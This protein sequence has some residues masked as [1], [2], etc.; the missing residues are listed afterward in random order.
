MFTMAM[1]PPPLDSSMWQ[2]TVWGKSN[3]AAT[4]GVVKAFENDPNL[5]CF[6]AT[7][8]GD[9]K[10]AWAHFQVFQADDPLQKWR[11]DAF[12]IPLTGPFPIVTIQPPRD[13]SWGGIVDGKDGKGNKTKQAVVIDRV[14]ANELGQPADLRRRVSRSV[15]LWTEKLAASGFVPPAK[16]VQAF[17]D[18]EDV[19]LARSNSHGQKAF[20]WGPTQPPASPSVNPQWPPGGPPADAQPQPLTLEQVQKAAPDADAKFW[21]EELEKKYTDPQKVV[22]DWMLKKTQQTPSTPSSNLGW[23]AMILTLLGGGSLGGAITWA[24]TAVR[25][26]RKATGQTLL[27]PSDATFDEFMRLFQSLG[28]NPIPVAPGTTPTTASVSPVSALAIPR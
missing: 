26:V 5:A 13:G 28:H 20:P 23:V 25:K 18:A 22:F 21:L 10:L 17:K 19:L 14:P 15:N 1:A 16:T 8:P 11:F 6:V 9:G 2:L 4:L 7:P 27:I 24:L 12:Q 3:D